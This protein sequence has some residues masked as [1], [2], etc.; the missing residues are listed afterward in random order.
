M[1]H[2]TPADNGRRR[3]RELG[4]KR[5][6]STRCDA[7]I[8]YFETIS[9]DHHSS[10]TMAKQKTVVLHLHPSLFALASQLDDHLRARITKI[11]IINRNKNPLSLLFENDTLIN[12]YSNNLVDSW[13]VMGFFFEF[14]LDSDVASIKAN[15]SI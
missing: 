10:L 6:R 13:H 5:S 2:K 4:R 8:G 1:V 11:Y 14:L 9:L 15:T 3:A 12:L 7:I